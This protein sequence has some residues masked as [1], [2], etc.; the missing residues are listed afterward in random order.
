MKEIVENINRFSNQY[1]IKLDEMEMFETKKNRL[2]SEREYEKA[3]KERDG[4]KKAE[5]ESE[6]VFEKLK[7]ELIGFLTKLV[8]SS[9][10]GKTF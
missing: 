1:L 4:W 7:E 10:K 2:V 9:L 5:T 8:N 3:A 6:I